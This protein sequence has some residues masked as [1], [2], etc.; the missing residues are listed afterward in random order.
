[1]FN[2]KNICIGAG[3][4]L[5]LAAVVSCG[6]GPGGAQ[7]GGFAMPPTPVEVAVVQPRD[8][9]DK[10]EVVG[11]I[12]AEKAVTIVSEIDGAVISIPFKEGDYLPKGAL[13]A[14]IDTTQLA[15]ELRRADALVSQ[16]RNSYERIKSVVAQ[17]AG[18]PQDLDDAAATLKV[19]EANR[20][21]AAARFVK[22]RITAPFSGM[23][24]ARRVSPGAFLRGG[25]AI[26]EMANID[27]LRVYFSAPERFLGQLNRGAEVKISTTA[28]PGVEQSGKIEVIEPTLDAATRSVRIIAKVTNAGR[29]LRPGMSADVTA[30]LSERP[31]AL[32]IPNESVFVNGDQAFVFVV[33]D[34]STVARAALSLGT[35]LSDVVEVL[36]GLKTGQRIV[37]A[38]HQKL[39]DG[40]K[41]MPVISQPEQS[42]AK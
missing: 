16:S 22:T 11:T 30:I 5:L 15:A 32:A 6:G 3:L 1:M 25:Q 40:A 18:A 10:F 7:G 13:I 20:A 34:D 24:G 21:L 8:I 29:K 31:N 42:A 12:E 2:I 39:Y 35:R 28:F 26:T 23:V 38:G 33:K 14:L 41:V 4:M 27:E 19:A 17:N 36:D 37:R 9:S